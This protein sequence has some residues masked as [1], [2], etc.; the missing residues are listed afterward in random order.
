MDIFFDTV[1]QRFFQVPLIPV[2]AA[3][4]GDLSADCK[5]ETTVINFRTV[6]T[7][8]T[9][10]EISNRALGSGNNLES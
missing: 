8:V 9:A 6:L 2:I 7:H 1:A 3:A 10:C 4:N 5:A